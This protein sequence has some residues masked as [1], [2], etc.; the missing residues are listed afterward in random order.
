MKS[1]LADGFKHNHEANRR[2]ILS[3][4]NSDAVNLSAQRLFS[5]VLV[6]HNIW[7]SRIQNP[8]AA[9]GMDPWAEIPTADFETLNDALSK[10]ALELVE[11]DRDF[12]E[13][14]T[15]T[16]SKNESYSNTIGEICYHILSH[17]TYH[18]G[19]IATLNRQS[20][21]EPAITDYI[22]YKRQG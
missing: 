15:Y 5:H 22:F 20:G 10:R 11:S 13:R 7:L 12:S 3:F 16:N 2:V 14:I 6:A 4:L 18:R 1:I 19:Q 21:N 8:E 17:S 9:K